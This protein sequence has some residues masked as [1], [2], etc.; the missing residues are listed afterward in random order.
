M[1][2][3]DVMNLDPGILQCRSVGI[4]KIAPE[5]LDLARIGLAG[6]TVTKACPGGTTP[7]C[8]S[9]TVERRG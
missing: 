8:G 3:V 4:G 6:E 2:P 5:K 1:A 7:P 9:A